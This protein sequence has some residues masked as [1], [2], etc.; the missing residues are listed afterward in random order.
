MPA[1]IASSC[2]C[3][4]PPTLRELALLVPLLLLS[5]GTIEASALELL[6]RLLAT[7]MLVP[8]PSSSAE[9]DFRLLLNE[10]ASAGAAAVSSGGF[11]A[12]LGDIPLLFASVWPAAALF[13][14]CSTLLL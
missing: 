2:L 4:L 8:D 7:P 10:G 3:F 14:A 6:R 13:I 11:I 12:R 5:D 1:A 9:E